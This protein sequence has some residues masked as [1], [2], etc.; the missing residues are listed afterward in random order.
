MFSCM[1]GKSE[2]KIGMYAT[3]GASSDCATTRANLEDMANS[4][5]PEMRCLLFNDGPAVAKSGKRLMIVHHELKFLA[6]STQRQLS[7]LSRQNR[8]VVGT[9][10]F[11][12]R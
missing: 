7:L 1:G 6:Q 10:L 3:A 2:P 9:S 8:I 12:K 5:L 4:A 11:W